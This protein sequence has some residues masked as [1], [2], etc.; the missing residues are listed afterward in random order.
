VRGMGGDL[1]HTQVKGCLGLQTA[2]GPLGAGGLCRT[3]RLPMRK[4]AQGGSLMLIELA[5]RL[6]ALK[7]DT[8]AG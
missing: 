8:R 3:V 2:A 7:R 1:G 4:G 6:P 5:V